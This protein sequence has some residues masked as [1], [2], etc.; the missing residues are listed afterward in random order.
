MTNDYYKKNIIVNHLKIYSLISNRKKMFSINANVCNALSLILESI[1]DS[2]IEKKRNATLVM[3]EI[4]LNNIEDNNIEDNNNDGPFS[5]L[6]KV[7]YDKA[8]EGRNNDFRFEEYVHKFDKLL[9]KNNFEKLETKK[10]E[11]HIVELVEKLQDQT[12]S[13]RYYLEKFKSQVPSLDIKK[14]KRL[15]RELNLLV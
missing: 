2:S 15:K 1:K 7:F 13:G 11:T 4:I 10:L 3:F 8:V 9:K 6:L 14:A 5:R 12:N